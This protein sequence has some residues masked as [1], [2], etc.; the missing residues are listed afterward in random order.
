MVNY[1]LLLPGSVEELPP[2]QLAMQG[3]RRLGV[4]RALEKDLHCGHAKLDCSR[5]ASA[6][7]INFGGDPGPSNV[8]RMIYPDRDPALT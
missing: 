7:I 1:L 6:R 5:S 2:E 4:F 3:D 8:I